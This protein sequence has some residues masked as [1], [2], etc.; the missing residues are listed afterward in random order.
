VRFHL[1]SL[2]TL[3]LVVQGAGAD[4]M[5]SGKAPV[6]SPGALAFAPGGILLLGDSLGAQ[7]VAMDTA[8]RT[9]AQPLQDG[10]QFNGVAEKIGALLGVAPDQILVYDTAVNPISGNVYLSISRGRGPD[11]QTLILKM[12]HE[13]NFSEL[14]LDHIRYATS[15]LPDALRG[16]DVSSPNSRMQTITSLQFI[17]GKVVVAGLSNEEFSSTLRVI[18]YPFAAGAVAP[19]GT[20]IEIFHT[21]HGAYETNAPVRTFVPYQVNGKAYILAAYTCTPLVKIPVSALKAGSQVTGATIAEMGP[22]NSPL[23]M[24]AYRKNGHDYVL[25]ANSARGVVRL[26]IDHL[27]DAPEIVSHNPN[28]NLPHKRFPEWTR[29]HQLKKVDESTGL[30]LTDSAGTLNL[31]VIALP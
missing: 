28:T 13:G 11:A 24:I 20:G 31:R 30:I 19:V 27:D 1:I 18:P 9:P 26:E 22:G 29:V 25:I 12:D 17:D 7:V 4:W 16:D 6:K 2:F 21:A 5:T 15:R 10:T 3:G 14:A 23:D 8:D